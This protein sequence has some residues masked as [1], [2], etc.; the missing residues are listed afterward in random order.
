MS[1]FDEIFYEDGVKNS[2]DEL[3]K[4]IAD[5][6][7]VEFVHLLWGKEDGTTKGRYYGP[8][9]TLLTNLERAKFR[10]LVNEDMDDRPDND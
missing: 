9:N 8:L 6:K 4:D 5:F 10:L 2:I 3:C 7:E 1:D